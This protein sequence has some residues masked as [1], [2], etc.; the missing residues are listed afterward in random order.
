MLMPNIKKI[1]HQPRNQFKTAQ[2]CLDCPQIRP[3]EPSHI[4][5]VSSANCKIGNEILSLTLYPINKPLSTAAKPESP[6]AITNKRKGASGSPRHN[7][8]PPY[9]KIFSWAP[10]HKYQNQA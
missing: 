10:I 2:D 5:I 6:S 7:P 4:K 3:Y 9:S 8:L 1:N